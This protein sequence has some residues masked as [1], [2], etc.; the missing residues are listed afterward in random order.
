MC[1]RT[2]INAQP[3]TAHPSFTDIPGDK[4]SLQ[5]NSRIS[6]ITLWV[7]IALRSE[8]ANNR[9]ATPMREG[10]EAQ[11]GVNLISFGFEADPN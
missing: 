11:I 7:N 1:A 9:P 2:M 10:S 6:R 8:G 5:A 3:Y 4:P